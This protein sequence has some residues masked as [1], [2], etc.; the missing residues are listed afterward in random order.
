M[1]MLASDM[2]AHGVEMIKKGDFNAANETFN[3]LL[4]ND[5]DS[6]T[7]IFNLASCA[8]KKNHLGVAI[9]LYKHLLTIK[10][11]ISEA[12][13]NMGCIYKNL[14]IMNKAEQCFRK[15]IE[16]DEGRIKKE[17]DPSKKQELK[18]NI[19]DFYSNLASLFVA[20]GTPLKAIELCDKGL[21]HHDA[22]VLHWNKSLALLEKGDYENGF[23]EY[24]YGFRMKGDVADKQD[25]VDRN[26]HKDGTPAWDGTK[27]K[28]VVVYGE[29]GIGDEIMFASMVPDIMKDCNVILDVHPRLADLFRNSFP[30]TPVFGTRKVKDIPW[31]DF[32]TID[33][34]LSIG[35][36]GK[37]Y[38]KKKE[39]FPGTPYIK[40]D[41]KLVEK[42]HEKLKS[43]GRKLNVGISWRGGT[44]KTNRSTRYIKLDLLK[45]LLSLDANF[46]SLQYNKDSR[47]D[48]D[49]FM[50]KN[51]DI[52][53][54]HW[55]DVLDDYDETAGLVANLDV[56]FSVPQSVVHLAGAMG[57]ETYQLTP[58]K[59]MWQMGPYGEDMPWYSCVKNIWQ[60]NDCKW[61]PVVD[62]ASKILK[63]MINDSNHG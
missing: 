22:R 9:I 42:Y 55:Q 52:A 50:E 62:K 20:D 49:V 3:V 60:G 36:L 17:N 61:E 25:R 56:I 21:K 48:V 54:H 34:K 13:N 8:S 32:G 16:I 46:I 47:K 4:N 41:D 7:I 45:P 39:D 35:S 30:N 44:K 57:V 26:Y 40:A 37:F 15:A 27:G 23:Q 29:Q 5:L 1:K 38:R 14:E 11:N 43:L 28:W 53:L 63:E 51:P 6:D 59:A 58:K 10:P 33:Y 2:Y 12:Y 31:A 18:I 19:A 24:E